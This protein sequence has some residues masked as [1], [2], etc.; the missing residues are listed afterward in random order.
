[1]TQIRL[2]LWERGGGGNINV[3]AIIFFR[4]IYQKAMK[5]KIKERE[6]R[7]GKRNRDG[8]REAGGGTDS[9]VASS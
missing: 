8:R 1:M 3:S 4:F 6:E 2:D 9:S 5:K 7:K